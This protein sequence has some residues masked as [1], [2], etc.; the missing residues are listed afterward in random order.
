MIRSRWIRY[1][2]RYRSRRVLPAV[3]M[4]FSRETYTPRGFE[5]GESDVVVD[6]GANSPAEL[7]P[8]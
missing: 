4:G 6:G 1:G 2:R 8:E 5:I 3:T 7:R